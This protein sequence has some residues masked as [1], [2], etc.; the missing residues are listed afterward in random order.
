MEQTKTIAEQYHQGLDVLVDNVLKAY[1]EIVRYQGHQ[2]KVS[3]GDN[4]QTV[5]AKD[6]LNP[7]LKV[8]GLKVTGDVFLQGSITALKAI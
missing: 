4:D 6:L 2:L 7:K 3:G 8:L 5:I 1:F